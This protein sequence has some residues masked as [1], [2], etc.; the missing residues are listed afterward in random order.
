MM[1]PDYLSGFKLV[2]KVAYFSLDKEMYESVL[3]KHLLRLSWKKDFQICSDT[4]FG[5]VRPRFML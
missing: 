5:D 3:Q 1:S 2:V 4:Q